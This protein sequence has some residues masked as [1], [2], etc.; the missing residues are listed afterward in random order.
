MLLLENIL[1]TPF[2]RKLAESVYATNEQVIFFENEVVVDV[3]LV[4]LN[5]TQFIRGEY[6][7]K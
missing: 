4:I 6:E 1:R 3:H 5:E 7:G 2:L